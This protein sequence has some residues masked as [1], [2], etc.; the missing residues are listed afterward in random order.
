MTWYIFR[1]CETLSN[2][3]KTKFCGEVETLLTL[4]G[5]DQAKS[6][7]HRL[8]NTQEDFSKFEFIASPLARTRH[9][10][11]IILE[12]LKLE[13]K[14]LVEEP[15]LKTKYRGDLEGMLRKEAEVK[16]VESFKERDRD[17]WNWC[18][19]GNGESHASE[20]QRVLKFIDKYKEKDNLFI[21]GH[22][23]TISVLVK[24]LEGWTEE[25]IKSDRKNLKFDQNY[26]YSYNKEN[27]VVTKL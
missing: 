14:E 11:Q 27:K 16:Y 4:R 17:F 13:D 21:C 15:L 18:P 6:I 2:K 3:L 8:I 19:P 10:T 1:H 9:T 5:I 20:Y 25:Q 24:V 23:G 22:Q 12:L 7:G 26:F